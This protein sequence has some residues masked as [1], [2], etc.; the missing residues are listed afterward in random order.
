[1]KKLVLFFTCFLSSFVFSYSLFLINDSPCELTAI[2]NAA[3]GDFLGQQSLQPGEQKQWNS[4]MKKTT[5]REIYNAKASTTPFTVTFQC[6]YEGTYS[7]VQDVSPGQVVKAS[8][9]AGSR[10]CKDKAE[11]AAEKCPACPECPACPAC[12]ACP[13]FPPLETKETGGT[14]TPAK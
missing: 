14:A 6:A 11:K 4:D 9:G 3:T 5:V 12:P 1:M 7:V 13:S 2:V 8:Q 10:T